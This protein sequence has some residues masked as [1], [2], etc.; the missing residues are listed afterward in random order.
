LVPKPKPAN[1]NVVAGPM[2]IV[3]GDTFAMTGGVLRE[4]VRPKCAVWA[5]LE[6]VEAGQ[7]DRRVAISS[8]EEHAKVLQSADAGGTVFDDVVRSVQVTRQSS[9][10]PLVALKGV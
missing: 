2:R 3:R 5:Q 9:A 1:A 4:F 8:S 6:F 10:I 7:W